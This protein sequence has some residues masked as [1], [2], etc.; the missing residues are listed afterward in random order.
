MHALFLDSNCVSVCGCVCV[1]GISGVLSV[2]HLSVCTHMWV[3]GVHWFGFACD[4]VFA[5]IR[6][7]GIHS[8]GPGS[9]AKGA[10]LS[11]AAELGTLAYCRPSVVGTFGGGPMHVVC[12]FG[13][14]CANTLFEL[15]LRPPARPSEF[16]FAST[17]NWRDAQCAHQCTQLVR[18]FG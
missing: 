3:C 4:I 5:D 6:L 12:V 16:G 14:F 1:C 15:R 7:N 10:T 13:R 18:Q 2:W 17:V 8:R 11:P 9:L